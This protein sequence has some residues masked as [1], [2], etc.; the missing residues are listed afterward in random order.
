VRAAFDGAGIPY[1]SAEVTMVPSMSVPLERDAAV[2]VLRLLDALE[3]LD[4]VQ[5]VYAN[6]DIPEAVLEAVAS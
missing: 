3:D 4:D 5:D 6:F 1:D 2:R